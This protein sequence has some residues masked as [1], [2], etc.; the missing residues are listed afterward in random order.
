MFKPL[1]LMDAPIFAAPLAGVTDLPYRKILREIAPDLPLLT[2]MNSCHS[3][4]RNAKAKRNADDFTQEGLIGAQIFGSN[5]PAM[6]EGAKILESR[7]AKWIDINM[8]CPVPKVATRALAGANLMRDHQ[9]AGKI[10]AAIRNAVKIPVSVKTRT[11]WDASTMNSA[12]LVKICA[13]NGADW[14]TIHGRTRAQGYAGTADW[15]EIAKIK[16]AS[17]IPVVANGDIKTA[18]DIAKAKEITDCDGV[19]IGRAIMGNPWALIGETQKDIA[20]LVLKHFEYSLEYYDSPNGLYMFRKHLA[21]YTSGMPGASDFRAKIN[22]LKDK[23]A[24]RA[25]IEDF[26]SL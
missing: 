25:A 11:G 19:M 14:A 20:N 17:N 16:A 22:E 10:V 24:L 1:Q 7:G 9:L 18:D 3:L 4:I 21:W 13:D 2:E 23:A 15:N 6:A 12:Q 8:G 26:F 5:V